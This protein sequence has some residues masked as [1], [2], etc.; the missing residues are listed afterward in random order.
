MREDWKHRENERE[1]EKERIILRERI[2]GLRMCASIGYD[3]NRYRD[4]IVVG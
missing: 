3:E 1:G 2:N 4:D